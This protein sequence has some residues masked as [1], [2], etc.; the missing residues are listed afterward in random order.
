M[1]V[2]RVREFAGLVKRSLWQAAQMMTDGTD[3]APY[4][5]F[6]LRTYPSLTTVDWSV[7]FVDSNAALVVSSEFSNRFGATL[8]FTCRLHREGGEWK[9]QDFGATPARD[10][11]DQR[12]CNLSRLFPWLKR[13]TNG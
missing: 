1:L 5:I 8:V 10:G 9:I 7:A 11:V 13:P 6:G 12:S 4:R 2:A 3:D